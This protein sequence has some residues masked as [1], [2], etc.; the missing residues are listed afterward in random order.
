MV[1]RAC[2]S[3]AYR[4]A[5]PLAGKQIERRRFARSAMRSSGPSFSSRVCGNSRPGGRVGVETTPF[6]HSPW[7][8][9]VVDDLKQRSRP[10]ETIVHIGLDTS[11]N[12]F[13]L[14]G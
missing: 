14:H 12:V 7:Q 9:E 3:K 4:V 5:Q 13:Q 2:R 8:D 10:V 1:I 11:K 6:R